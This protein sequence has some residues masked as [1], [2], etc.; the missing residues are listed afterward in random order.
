MKD[1]RKDAAALFDVEP[2]APEVGPLEEATKRQ[3]AKLTEDGFLSDAHAGQ[4]ALAIIAARDADRSQGRG[5]PS[6][7]ANL[8][9]VL[10]EIFS[11]IP[12]PEPVSQD[13]LDAAVEAIRAAA[14]A[15]A[16]EDVPTDVR[17]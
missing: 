11:N 17:T 8:Y 6:G 16:F 1:T 10:N 13:Q 15:E 12:Q 4:A 7:R 2:P 14:E 3:I 5:A 9:R